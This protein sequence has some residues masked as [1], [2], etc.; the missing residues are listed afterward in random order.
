MAARRGRSDAEVMA[1]L[2][3]AGRLAGQRA[4]LTDAERAR[5]RREQLERQQE[6]RGRSGL[7]K[8]RGPGSKET[9]D[10]LHGL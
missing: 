2:A 5:R 6:L 7:G 3:A 10:L 8:N 4:P 1:E 9:L